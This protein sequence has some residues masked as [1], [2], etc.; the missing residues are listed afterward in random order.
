[1]ALVLVRHASAGDREEWD[2]DDRLRPLD[3]KGR[4]QAAQLP[5]VVATTPIRRIV[6]SP[7]V[8]C[9]ETVQPLADALGLHVEPAAEL[10]EERQL[11]DG[12]RLL[13]ALLQDDAVACV[14][15]GIESA[16][17]FAAPFRK[18]AVWLF[19]HDLEAPQ[20]MAEG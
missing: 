7:Y 15:G 2:G 20:V 6:S 5:D 9:V 10:G 14:H 3:S 16:L 1:V 13:A 12:P 18:A 11:T 4:K 17:G 19:E 8:R